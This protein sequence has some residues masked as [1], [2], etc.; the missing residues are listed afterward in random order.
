MRR[1]DIDCS[2][3]YFSPPIA[4]E[5]ARS[6]FLVPIHASDVTPISRHIDGRRPGLRLGREHLNEDRNNFLREFDFF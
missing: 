6:Y 2:V 3:A 1:P 5:T 4:G